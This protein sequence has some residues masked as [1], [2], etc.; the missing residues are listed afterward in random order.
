M[1]SWHT[2]TTAKIQEIER[3]IRTTRTKKENKLS[4]LSV[5][6]L[7]MVDLQDKINRLLQQKTDLER[8]HQQMKTEVDEMS[9][10]IGVLDTK[11]QKLQDAVEIF[12]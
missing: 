12:T 9:D 4:E 7:R 10:E 6:K 1:A 3:D 5:Q 8:D 11:K 2:L